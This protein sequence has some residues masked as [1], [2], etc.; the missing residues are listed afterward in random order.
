MYL[1]TKTFNSSAI[2]ASN[3]S[4][5]L[6]M[7]FGGTNFGFTAGAND[8]NEHKYAPDI[9]SYDYDAVMDERG[10]I[11][12]KYQLIREVIGKYFRIPGIKP[13]S[14]KTFA[15]GKV[16]LKPIMNL[17]SQEGRYNL[18][19]VLAEKSLK[20]KSFEELDQFSGLIL[21]E[22]DIK[23]IDIENS[24]LTVNDLRDRG[25]I[26][27]DQQLI[28][29]LSRQ[30][31]NFSLQINKTSGSTLQILVE[32]QGRINY[33]IAND[34]KGIKGS[35]TLQKSAEIH[36]TLE[37]WLHTGYPLEGSHIKQLLNNP[38]KSITEYHNRL[39]QGPMIYYGEFYVKKP[40][41]TYLNPSGWGKGVA[42]VNGFNLGRYWPLAGPQLTLFVPHEVLVR[43]RNTL[44]IIEYEE[45][46][47]AGP[48]I[49][50]YMTLDSSPQLDN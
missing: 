45:T 13:V 4:V 14:E 30:N 37:N 22:T 25:L 39:T 38:F 9:T 23:G 6:Y 10:N 31:G 34:T 21:Y 8:F 7:F 28:G 3:A 17:L 42:Y 1:L 5:N 47:S 50:P 35:V 2:L 46:N 41:H 40:L 20:P 33:N 49:E 36:R 11:T 18:G 24:L 15:Y 44:T 26:Y 43:G 32:N 27:I 48:A 16:E 29:I 12:R 19:K